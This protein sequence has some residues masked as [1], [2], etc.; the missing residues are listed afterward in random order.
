M[1]ITETIDINTNADV[2]WPY[3][4][5]ID[6]IKQWNKIILEQQDLIEAHLEVGFI[7]SLLIEEKIAK[8]WYTAKIIEYE[9][10]KLLSFSLTGGNLGTKPLVSSYRIEPIEKNISRIHFKA[11]WHADRFTLRMAEPV[12][13]TYM[14]QTIRQSLK[15]LQS[16]F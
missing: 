9:V 4:I 13:Q 11:S 8:T 5:Q 1:F 14:K 10:L 3:L 12:I 6:K 15:R 7:C 2:L 16:I